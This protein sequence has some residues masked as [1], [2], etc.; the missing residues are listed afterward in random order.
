M[1][2]DVVVTVLMAVRDTP[3]RMLERAVASILA[4]SSIEFEFL[5]VDD[6][7]RSTETVETLELVRRADARIR[8]ERTEGTGLT[9][10]LNFGLGMAR[11]K[12]I[13]RQDADDWSE[14]ERLARQL[15]FCTA[16]PE[17]A[18]CGTAA[19]L[20]RF[21][22][23]KLW[24]AAMPVSHAAILRSFADGNPFFH[25]SA[26][27]LKT[28]AVAIGGYR[29]AFAC[30][31]DYDFF[32]R[33][34]ERGGAANLPDALYHYRY[35]CGSVSALRAG[36][37]SR[38]HRAARRL[39]ESRRRGDTEDFV[40]AFAEDD[41]IEAGL[42]AE[43]KQADHALLAGNYGRAARAYWELAWRDPANWMAWGKL[44]RWG[45]FVMAPPAREWCFR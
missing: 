37:Q 16:H 9:R 22:G 26:L 25:G 17:T 8:L 20:H 3:R 43:L 21:D 13:A 30:S 34:A 23:G 44:A 40:A 42:S 31:Q 28:A 27:F 36:E 11:G 4:Q 29:E 35:G 45:V 2:R 5:I 15:E 12:W 19:W 32:W 33:L 38:A 18:L 6:G 7:S 24:R 1:G 10:A 41:G 14:P 39:A